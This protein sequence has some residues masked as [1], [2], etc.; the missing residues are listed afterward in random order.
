MPHS[1][2]QLKNSEGDM[3]FPRSTEIGNVYHDTEALDTYLSTFRN[4]LI[5]QFYPLNAIIILASD[6]DP[7]SLM[8]GTTW[9][10]YSQG[11]ILVGIGYLD[12]DETK[13]EITHA[14][15]INGEEAVT[16]TTATMPSHNHKMNQGKAATG[17]SGYDYRN[18]G[19]YV[20]TQNT[21]G[22]G[23]HNNLMPYIAVNIWRRTE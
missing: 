22:G 3:L 4:E 7:N 1:I 23:A 8:P 13:Q 15:E 17:S 19:S 2:V 18:S 21:G 16:I 14:K 20:G 11:E 12:G 6:T 5:S 10:P 9:E